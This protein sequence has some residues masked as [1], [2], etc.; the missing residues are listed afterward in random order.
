MASHPALTQDH[1][2]APTALPG[3][4]TSFSTIPSPHASGFR[5]SPRGIRLS[6]CDGKK[7]AVVLK[8]QGHK[9][10]VR[11]VGHWLKDDVLG[12]AL[13]VPIDGDEASAAEFVFAEKTWQGEVTRDGLFGCDLCISLN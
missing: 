13:R 12:N 1:A 10:V 5:S 2:T 4:R 7:V 9:H 8:I 3:E 11:G 6:D